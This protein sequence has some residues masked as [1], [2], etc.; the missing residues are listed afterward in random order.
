MVEKRSDS[1]ISSLLTQAFYCVPLDLSE[2][3]WDSVLIYEVKVIGIAYKV[4]T[5]A[6]RLFMISLHMWAFDMEFG[7]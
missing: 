1:V 5:R 2:N 7:E 6:I 3:L 4:K